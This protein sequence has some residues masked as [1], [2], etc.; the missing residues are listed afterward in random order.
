MNWHRRSAKGGNM[1]RLRRRDRGFHGWRIG[2]LAIG[3][4]SRTGGRRR[5]GRRAALL[6]LGPR[7]GLWQNLGQRRRADSPHAE[8]RQ[9]SQPRKK[10]MV[11]ALASH[12]T[13]CIHIFR[14]LFK[15]YHTH[16]GRLAATG[17]NSPVRTPQRGN[18]RQAASH[19]TP[20]PLAGRCQP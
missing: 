6:S 5:R 20:S 9:P 17:K 19:H 4:R 8:C 7:C 16:M 1:S 3:S 13:N 15:N 10:K 11:H 18:I 2:W 14:P 12:T